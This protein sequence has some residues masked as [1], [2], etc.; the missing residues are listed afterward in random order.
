[1]SWPTLTPNEP[2]A[3]VTL[4]LEGTYPMVRGGVSGWV[5]QLIRGL[6]QQRFALIFLGGR[7][8][9]YDG[10][11]FE[12]PTNVVHLECHYL[13]DDVPAPSA[14]K[15][16]RGRPS[17]FIKI[18]ELHDGLRAPDD[19]DQRQTLCDVA[20]MIGKRDGIRQEDFL[21]SQ[22]AWQ[23]IVDHYLEHVT[24]PSF[25]DY[26]WSVRNIHAPLFM[27][28]RI[29]NNLPRS[30][31]LHAISTGYAGF[32]GALAHHI[33]QL[34][35]AITE[36]G[37]YTKERQIDLLDAKW[38][39]TSRDA[40]SHGFQIDT[41]YIR[42]MWIRF[43]QGLGRMTYASAAHI[44]TLHEGN[45]LRQLQDG[46]PEARTRLI[47]NG[48][49][50]ERFASLRDRTAH[51]R[52][53]VVALLGRVTPIKDIK[54]FIRAMHQLVGQL[55]DAEGWIVGPDSE[56][57]TY[58]Q[59]CR[60][61]AVQLGVESNVRF[62]G[63]Q[64]TED[65]L[66]KVRLVVLTSISEAQPLV[67]LE[68]MAAGLPVVCTDVGA[69]RDLVMGDADADAAGSIVPIANP[70]ATANAMHF[71]LTHP[72]AWQNARQAGITRVEA[73]Y[74]ETLM[75]ARYRQLYEDLI[76]PS[77]TASEVSPMVDSLLP[78]LSTR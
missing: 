67:V 18:R 4:L 32:L 13:M 23:Y 8:D 33:H 21:H 25:I 74:T 29:A 14:I 44:T 11:L 9:H 37:I 68:A 76:H 19:S 34:P 71:M 69:C 40:L 49:C 65:I 63:F 16:R 51:N 62:L 35:L 38:I 57:P 77:A 56:D 52:A 22:A 58:A 28:A 66:A 2:P 15:A 24:E 55:P 61:L 70:L 12:R 73:E 42:Q 47:P 39:K 26:F 72:A 45:R 17:A 30:R 75:L 5:D 59:E 41:G 6:P 46:A 54:T 1:M 64:R 7:R 48:I 53:P 50:I 60:D 10:I 36:H 20:R 3:D 27:L 31:C 78:A 43:F